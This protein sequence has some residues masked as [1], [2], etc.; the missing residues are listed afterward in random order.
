MCMIGIVMNKH[1]IPPSL[2]HLEEN[3]IFDFI[4]KEFQVNIPYDIMAIISTYTDPTTHDDDISE[5]FT[6]LRDSPTYNFCS[7]AEKKNHCLGEVHYCK[8]AEEV[9]KRIKQSQLHRRHY[10]LVKDH[11]EDE[12]GFLGLIWYKI[13][14]SDQWG[15]KPDTTLHFICDPV[16]HSNFIATISYALPHAIH[17][18]RRDYISSKDTLLV[19]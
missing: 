3:Y 2:V 19:F 8:S 10:A 18:H 5:L 7:K 13:K 17:I 12:I 14:N 15:A 4:A 11:T 1:G 16:L 6:Y 9:I